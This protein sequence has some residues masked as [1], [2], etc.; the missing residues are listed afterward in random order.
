MMAYKTRK[1][2]LWNLKLLSLTWSSLVWSV[3][4]TLSV[5][6]QQKL[7]VSLRKRVSAQSWSRVTT[8]I[9][10]KRLPNV[11]ESSIQMIRRPCLHRGWVEWTHWWRIPK[12]SSK[13]YSVYARVSPEHKVRIVKAWQNEGKLL[14]WLVIGSTM[15]HHLRQLIS[16]SVWGLQVRGF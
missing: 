12:K 5:Q 2:Q 11:L 10:Q 6:K 14:P 3:W 4:L 15:H 7:F 8:K 13:Q 9:Q 16:V 1:I